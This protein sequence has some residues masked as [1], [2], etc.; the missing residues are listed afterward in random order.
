MLSASRTEAEG[1]AIPQLDL[2]PRDVERFMPELAK[3]HTVFQ[4]LMGLASG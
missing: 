3:F 1:C 2:S 4:P